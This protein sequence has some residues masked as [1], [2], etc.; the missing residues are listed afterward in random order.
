MKKI[1]ILRRIFSPKLACSSF[2][3]LKEKAGA[4]PPAPAMTKGLLM[5]GD[6]GSFQW[7]ISN[8]DTGSD[9][10]IAI[11]PVVG[12]QFDPRWMTGSEFTFTS[13][14]QVVGGGVIL[15]AFDLSVGLYPFLRLYINPDDKFN[16]F[17]E[18][19]AGAANQRHDFHNHYP[20]R[21]R[22]SAGVDFFLFSNMALEASFG[23][24]GVRDLDEGTIW[25]DSLV[26]GIGLRAFVSK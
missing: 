14:Q 9:P 15:D 13:G 17:A 5:I 23:Y 24:Q 6:Q 19:M 4:A 21:L 2:F 7:N 16:V 1:S 18:G 10:I 26:G 25:K 8:N 20:F 12:Y 22:G 11:H 3:P